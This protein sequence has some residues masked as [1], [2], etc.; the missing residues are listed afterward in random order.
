G[1]PERYMAT[2]WSRFD[3]TWVHGDWASV[4]EDGFWYLHGRSDDTLNIAG[5]RIGPAEIE[6]VAVALDEVVMAAAIGVPDEIKGETIALFV[7]PAP[8]VTPDEDLTASVIA[9]CDASLGKAFRPSSVN[10]VDD[11]PRT[12]SQKIMRRVVKAVA[13]GNDPGDVTSLENPQSL[14]GL[15]RL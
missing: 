1:E 15:Q 4:D 11:L 9:N 6:S 12:R 3:D 14:K 13:L 2:Y 7:V 8:G 5:K 10:W